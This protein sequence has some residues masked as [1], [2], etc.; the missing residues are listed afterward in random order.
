MK[1]DITT[2]I[3]DRHKTQ[4]HLVQILKIERDTSRLLGENAYG[5]PW[6]MENIYYELP[7]KWRYSSIAF[8]DSRL[9][10]YLIVSRWGENLHGHRM[11]MDIDLDGFV[12]VR[13][14]QAL[15][16]ESSIAGRRDGLVYFS[17][18][19]PTE[20]TSTQRYYLREGFEQ[21]DGANLNWF[22]HGKGFDG[23]ISGDIL[24]DREPVKGEPSASYVYRIDIRKAYL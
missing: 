20:N 8:I 9:A 14:A 1:A 19:V 3:L 16:K 13:I 21:L 7:G 5:N 4:T 17:A 10:G 11:G 2:T 12:K 6:T 24:L 15:Y 18:I 22:I 23:Y